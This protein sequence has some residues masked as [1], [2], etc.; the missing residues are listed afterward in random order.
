MRVKDLIK[1]LKKVN[2]EAVVVGY[3][4]E[5]ETDFEVRSIESVRVEDLEEVDVNGYTHYTKVDSYAG[6]LLEEGHE[7]VYLKD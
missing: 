1:E 6:E 4:G 2:P 3:S 7:I 5:E